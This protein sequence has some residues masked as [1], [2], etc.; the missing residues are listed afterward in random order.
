MYS[1]CSL[2]KYAVMSESQLV[3]QHGQLYNYT[4][5]IQHYEISVSPKDFTVVFDVVPLSIVQLFKGFKGNDNHPTLL[6]I[7]ETIAGKTCFSWQPESKNKVICQFFQ[8]DIISTPSALSYW[9]TFEFCYYH[10]SKRCLLKCFTGFIQLIIICRNSDIDGSWTFCGKLR[11]TLEHC[12]HTKQLWSKLTRFI[13]DHIYPDFTLLWENV[14]FEFNEYDE[15]LCSQFYLSNSL[16]I[17]TKFYIH[18]SVFLSK[19]QTFQRSLSISNNTFIQ[20]LKQKKLLK[21][22]NIVSFTRYLIKYLFFITTFSP[23]GVFVDTRYC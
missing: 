2:F 13:A 4:Q 16:S 12:R 6:D 7:T 10:E 9:S 21:C 8:Q 18:K 22:I 20:Y 15:N 3:N 1:V 19:S 17:L 23:P 14:L 11:E 5:L